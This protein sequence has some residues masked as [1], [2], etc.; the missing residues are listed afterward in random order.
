MNTL[1]EQLEQ[2]KAD[3]NKAYDKWSKAYDDWYK[4]KSDA[5]LEKAEADWHK[6]DD[7]VFRIK[8]LIKGEQAMKEDTTPT[9]PK[10]DHGGGYARDIICAPKFM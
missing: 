9:N 7:E 6:A 5:D 8:A 1:Q 10:W 2:A 4:T 3:W